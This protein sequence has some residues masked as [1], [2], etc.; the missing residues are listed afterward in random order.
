MDWRSTKNAIELIRVSTEQQAGQ[1]R[2][3]IPA[4]REANRRTASLYGLTIVKSIEII[5]VSGAAVLR[6]P[7]MKELLELMESPEIHGIVA[8]EFSRLMRPEN[9]S[10]YA[11]LQHFIDTRTVLY[12]PEGPIDFASKTGRLYGTVR[13]AM[14]GLERREIIER[15]QDGKEALRRTG[16]HTGGASTLPFGVDYSKVGG[17]CYTAEAEKVKVAFSLFL[18]GKG[19]NDIGKQLNIPR[20]NVRFILQNPIYMG[21]RVYKE[22]RDPSSCA[23]R[24]RSD[25]RQGYRRKMARAPDEV[26]KVKVLDG[27]VSGDDFA[28]VQELIDIKRQKHWRARTDISRRYT[29]N[30]CLVCGDCS[31]PI[32]THTSKHDFYVCKSHN[33]RERKKR[34]RNG[35]GPCNN[36]HMLRTKLER[37]IDYLLAIKLQE[38]EFLS[39]LVYGYNESLSRPHRSATA[40]REDV[41]QKIE[42]LQAR[43]QRIL[44]AFLDGV[45]DKEDRDGRMADIDRELHVYERLLIAVGAQPERP[46]E[47]D[48]DTLI[49]IVEAFADWEF[50]DREDKRSLLAHLCPEISVSYYEIKSL[51]LRHAGCGED[52][53]ERTAWS[54]SRAP[55]SA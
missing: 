39:R 15:M 36:R 52:S 35:L 45:I 23:Y 51:T 17:W 38:K 46:Q 2:A 55:P 29:Y 40:G 3:G 43:R 34:E 47:L 42:G 54:P 8:K 22:K 50:L 5:D 10:D 7:K 4:Q 53:Q 26:I 12:L 41:E 44:E 24:P 14:A 9:F 48:L 13:A 19:Y 18:A 16:K 31:C 33:V 49:S 25:G 30:G 1:D 21:W 32:Y 28:R 6:S 27:L 37:R 20:T 11:L